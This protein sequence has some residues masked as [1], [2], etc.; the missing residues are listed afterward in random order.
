MGH[1]SSTGS[2]RVYWPLH[3]ATSSNYKQASDDHSV[4]STH[5]SEASR[6]REAVLPQQDR[7]TA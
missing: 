3:R 5:R 4:P 2:S 6:P 1:G 7:K